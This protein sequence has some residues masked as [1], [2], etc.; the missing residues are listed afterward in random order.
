MTR[1]DRILILLIVCSLPFL[2]VHQWPGNETADSLIIQH[3]KDDPVTEN[4]QPNRMLEISGPLGVSIIEIRDGRTRFV[5]SP[6]KSQV[7]VHS[8]WLST[9]GGFIACLPNRISVT[10]ADQHARF[11]AI[12]F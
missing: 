4:L 12:N 9:T 5:S 10:L 2:Y 6:C 1:A 3:G 11:D 8:G 7:C